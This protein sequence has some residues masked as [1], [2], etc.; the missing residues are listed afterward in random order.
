M[1]EGVYNQNILAVF[2]TVACETRLII[3]FPP[4]NFKK[5]RDKTDQMER[6]EKK[7]TKHVLKSIFNRHQMSSGNATHRI[8][9]SSVRLRNSISSDLVGSLVVQCLCVFVVIVV[10]SSKRESDD[11]VLPVQAAEG[12]DGDGAEEVGDPAQGRCAQRSA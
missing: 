3:R 5:K 10:S 6:T 1:T 8:C 11:D 2:T 4:G 9:C 7:C 12:D